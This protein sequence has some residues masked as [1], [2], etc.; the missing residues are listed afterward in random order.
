M[1]PAVPKPQEKVC[2]SVPHPLH[3]PLPPDRPLLWPPLSPNPRRRYVDQSPAPPPPSRPAAPMAPAVPKPQEKVCRSVPLH[4]PLPPDRPLLWPLL[5]PNPRRRYVDQSPSPPPPSR[6]AAPM[7]PAVPKPQEKVRRSD[8]PPLHLPPDRP[9]LW[10]PLSPN[11]RRRY[12]D[13]SPAPS[14]PSLQTGR[15]YGPR[16]PQTPGEGM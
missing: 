6:P 5:S 1:A 4:L 12:V 8:P 15:S 2:R 16:C 10:P 3:L 13:Q 11:P 14:P 7:A 9:L